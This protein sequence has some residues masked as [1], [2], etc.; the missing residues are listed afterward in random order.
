MNRVDTERS[1]VCQRTIHARE[2]S[3][4]STNTLLATEY[5]EQARPCD[6][7]FTH[8]DRLGAI[9]VKREEENVAE[10]KTH[11]KLL[12]LNIRKGNLT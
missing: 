7:R 9:N 6:A 11:A 5:L 4:S 8:R 10:Y 2:T 3:G 12:W 1:S